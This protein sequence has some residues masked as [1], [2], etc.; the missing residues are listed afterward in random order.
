MSKGVQEPVTLDRFLGGRLRIAQSA[1]G[2]RAG[3]DTV[4]LAAAVP[5]QAG[6]RVL[7]LGSGAGVASLC[8]AA[9]VCGAHILGIEIDADA[10]TL[11]NE[12]AA[13]NGMEGRVRFEPGDAANADSLLI[14]SRSHSDRLEG[15]DHVFFNPP[16][17]PP[18]G[19]RSPNATRAR[20]MHDNGEILARWTRTALALTRSGGTVTAILPANRADEMLISKD[21]AVLFPFFPHAGEPAKRAI[22]RIVKD[23]A[24]PFRIASGLVLH[25][26][27]GRN[28]EAAETVLRYG[29]EL[30]LV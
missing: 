19:Q 21:G 20:A 11:A 16:F 8:L 17:H 26:A 25:E 28:T 7:E 14:L 15:Y 30:R 12:N 13:R 6:A 9:R 3:H 2:F 1:H 23:S 24:L 18:T 22:V 27:D 4:L 10:V 29:A 5:A